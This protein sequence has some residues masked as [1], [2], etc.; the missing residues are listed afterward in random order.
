MEVPKTSA[1]TA[2]RKWKTMPRRGVVYTVAPSH[3]DINTIWAA[4][5]DGLIHVTRDGGKN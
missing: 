2:R 5:D 1:F 4:T 3:K